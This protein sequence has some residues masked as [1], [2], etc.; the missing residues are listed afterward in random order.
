MTKNTIEMKCENT[1]EPRDFSKK[2]L[3]NPK[4][5]DTEYPLNG[6]FQVTTATSTIHGDLRNYS[7]QNTCYSRNNDCKYPSNSILDDQRNISI[8]LKELCRGLGKEETRKIY[9]LQREYVSAYNRGD[10]KTAI[11]KTYAI[12]GVFYN[13][14]IDLLEH[15]SKLSRK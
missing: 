8:P 11:E 10:H 2:G 5:I 12:D 3:L 14:G 4:S 13:N 1:C 7:F 6:D 9:A 15:F